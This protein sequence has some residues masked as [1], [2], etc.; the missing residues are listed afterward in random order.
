MSDPLVDMVHEYEAQQR[1]QRGLRPSFSQGI[2]GSITAGYGELDPSGYWQFPL[3]PGE[4]YL[5]KYEK[6][7]KSST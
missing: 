6:R 2:C 4:L 7:Y 5:E 1:W 3:Y